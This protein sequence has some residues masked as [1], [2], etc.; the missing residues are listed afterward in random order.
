MRLILVSLLII[1]LAYLGYQFTQPV[2][3]EQEK[4]ID[5]AVASG[6][7][8]IRLLAEIS[9]KPKANNTAPSKNEP[10]CWAVGPYPVELDAKHL[11]ARMLAMDIPAKVKTQSV[12]IKEEFWVYLPPMANRKQ[13]MRKLNELQKRKVDS[14]VITEGELENGISLGLFGKQESVDRLLAKLKEKNITAS[15]KPLKRTRNQYWVMAPV[16][17]QYPMDDKTRNR[18]MEGRDTSWLQIRC[19]SGLP[20]A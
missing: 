1:N 3:L 18:L 13:A 17:A 8:P 19:D 2:E 15:V 20:Q 9:A 14:F 11:Y 16:N 12:V 10:L 4:S 5:V 6:A 7:E